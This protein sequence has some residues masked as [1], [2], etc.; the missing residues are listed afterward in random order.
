MN[1]VLNELSKEALIELIS[2][3]SKNLLALDGVWFQSVE[4]KCGMDEAMFHDCEAWRRFTVTEARRIKKFLK[5]PERPGLTGLAS[6]LKLRFN[7]NV[8]AH[9]AVLQDGR[10]VFRNLE[11]AVQKARQGK[12]MPLHPCK[13]VGL[14]EYSGFAAEIDDRISCRCVSCYP[15]KTE[16]GTGCAWEFSIAADE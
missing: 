8:N 16:G 6:A 4:G 2:V 7:A 10:L 14:I 15:D 9:E 1:P 11:C 3:Y 13:P 5:L 12:G